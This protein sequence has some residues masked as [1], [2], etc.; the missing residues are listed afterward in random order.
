MT[1]HAYPPLLWS[2]EGKAERWRHEEG[3][4]ASECLFTVSACTDKLVRTNPA[5]VPAIY[6]EDGVP[7]LRELRLPASLWGVRAEPRPPP[8]VRCPHFLLSAMETVSRASRETGAPDLTLGGRGASMAVGSPEGWSR[9]I[10]LSHISAASW[11]RALST[12]ETCLIGQAAKL[13]PLTGVFITGV[14]LLARPVPQHGPGSSLSWGPLDNRQM[15]AG[16]W[17]TPLPPPAPVAAKSNMSEGAEKPPTSAVML[18]SSTYSQVVFNN[19]GQAYPPD[20]AVKCEYTVTTQFKPSRRDW[21]GIFRVGWSTTRDYYTF[22]WVAPPADSEGEVPKEQQVVFQAYYLPK[23]DGE[24]Y[25]FCYVDCSGQVRGASTPFRFQNSADCSLEADLLVITTQEQVEQVEKE[26]ADLQREA[27]SQRETIA[28]L[29]GELEDRLLELR[30]LRDS[31]AELGETLGKLQQEK[32]TL[33]RGREEEKEQWEREKAQLLAEHEAAAAQCVVVEQQLSQSCGEQKGFLQEKEVRKMPETS[34]AHTRGH[35]APPDGAM[36]LAQHLGG[37]MRLAQHLGGAMRLAHHQCT[38]MQLAQHLGGAMELQRS[39]KTLQEKN[40]RALAKIAEQRQE[41]DELRGRTEEQE[42]EIARLKNKL[43]ELDQELKRAREELRS[44]EDRLQLLQVDLQSSQKEAVK[45]AGELRAA[46]AAAEEGERLRSEVRV[47]RRSL[48]EKEEMGDSASEQHEALS[49]R[50]QELAAQLAAEKQRAG[51]QCEELKRAGE[52]LR[53]ELTESQEQLKYW[54]K[55]YEKMKELNSK[56]EIQ[57]M[58][59]RQSLEEQD[60][61]TQFLTMEKEELAEE[62]KALVSR[63]ERLQEE[64]AHLQRSP[65]SITLQHPNPYVLPAPIATVPAN[66]DLT[67]ESPYG[68]AVS[69]LREA[70]SRTEDEVKLCQYCQEQFPG[71]SQEELEEHEQSHKVCPFCSLICDALEQQEF[72]DHVVLSP[73]GCVTFRAFR[74]Y[75]CA[76][77]VTSPAVP[78]L[79][80][81]RVTGLQVVPRGFQTS[82]VSRDIDTAAKFIGAGAATVGVAGS[83]A[84]IGTVFGSLIIGYARNP[85]LKQQLFSYAI[86]GFAL[87]EAMGLFCLMVAFLILFAM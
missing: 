6:P 29:Q 73:P 61:Q 82:A 21:L 79:P 31:N 14:Q 65:A 83:G 32:A 53:A 72:E 20:S 2:H 70:H 23:E 76:K 44:Q 75:T 58:E 16:H 49:R 10:T 69:L 35:R 67:Y 80:H 27:D 11:Q 64:I 18:G 19:V 68:P 55:G 45:L 42:A 26:K 8:A 74:M 86:L 63:L 36:R 43:R 71:I 59:A 12:R 47:L 78:L 39:V 15:A 22:V 9:H 66:P 84:G 17:G 24:F 54:T 1:Q 28:I 40:E 4:A 51:Q 56:V 33:E 37:A 34:V 81:S 50:L 41:K 62:N 46:R 52:R 5:P 7:G 77:F 38:A 57:L 3:T 87:S 60:N 48:S 85:S 13:F 30:R 25:Q